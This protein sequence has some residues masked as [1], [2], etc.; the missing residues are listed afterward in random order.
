MSESPNLAPGQLRFARGISLLL[1]PPMVALF[2]VI[3]F[4]FFSPIGTGLLLA[5][6]SF[7]LGLAFVV[8][9]PILPLSTMVLL[10][11]ITIDV[12]DRRDRPIL[13]VAA[14]MV[15]FVGAIV[16]VFFV[17]YTMMVIALAYAAVTSAIALMSLFWKVSAHS[18]GVAGPVTGLI[19]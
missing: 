1:S 6:Q 14:I 3:S 19:W 12:K 10:G 17:D 13:Y 16:A 15:Y 11:K 2:T 5:W 9:G 7:L 18:A 8:V 4:A